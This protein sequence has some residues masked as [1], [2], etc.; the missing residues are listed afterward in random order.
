MVAEENDDNSYLSY[1]LNE[2]QIIKIEKLSKLN[3]DT[4]YNNYVYL[5]Y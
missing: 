5:F 2:S 1:P 4:N 3:F